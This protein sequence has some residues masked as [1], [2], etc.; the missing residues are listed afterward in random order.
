MDFFKLQTASKSRPSPESLKQRN[1]GVID[2][3]D[4]RS[5]TPNE[6]P[7]VEAQ[8]Y[9]NQNDPSTRTLD[10]VIPSLSPLASTSLRNNQFLHD[11]LMST[12]T[13]KF[14]PTASTEQQK[15]KK[16]G[17]E[18]WSDKWIRIAQPFLSRFVCHAEEDQFFD[19]EN[20]YDN[21]P[22]DSFASAIDTAPFYITPTFT[23]EIPAISPSTKGITPN[24]SHFSHPNGSR[25]ATIQRAYDIF[26]R[27]DEDHDHSLKKEDLAKVLAAF[28]TKRTFSDEDVSIK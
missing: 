13:A 1:A 11:H 8:D 15:S 3:V 21:H 18:S 7:S 2:G 10:S 14:T 6:I 12:L 16:T 20:S 4:R 5:M 9:E 26:T 27:L 23:S 17:E 25:L 28:S 19:A 22:I 24:T